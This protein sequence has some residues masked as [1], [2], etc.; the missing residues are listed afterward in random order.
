MGDSIRFTEE[1][2]EGRRVLVV[3]D[4]PFIA[5]DIAD[6]IETAGGEVIGPAMTVQEALQLI[7]RESVD[8]AILDVNLPDGD[9]GP[10]LTALRA[11]GIRLLIHTAAGLTPELQMQHPTLSVFSKPTPPPV[12]AQA[13]A[14]SLGS[15]GALRIAE[16]PTPLL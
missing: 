5:F 1:R 15:Q 16:P 12:L 7:A 13:I 9:I 14:T 11:K 10:V 3:E 4:E 2:L 6:A 8:A